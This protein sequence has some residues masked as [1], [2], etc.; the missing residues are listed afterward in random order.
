MQPA[1]LTCR[2][3]RERSLHSCVQR[4]RRLLT[5]F[6]MP[7]FERFRNKQEVLYVVVYQLLATRSCRNMAHRTHIITL[8]ILIVPKCPLPL[9]PSPPPLPIT[10][11]LQFLH[12]RVSR[13]VPDFMVL[14]MWSWGGGYGAKL[15]A[16]RSLALAP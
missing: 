15:R 13:E 7:H 14:N 1:M 16:A 6:W 11:A 8:E 9:L 5:G 2:L 10:A 12:R 3:F 4:F